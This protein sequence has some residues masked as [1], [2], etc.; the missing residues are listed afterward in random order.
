[1]TVAH[2]SRSP[3]QYCSHKHRSGTKIVGAVGV[4]SKAEKVEGSMCQGLGTGD[5][6]V[7]NGSVRVARL[8]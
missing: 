6:R 5:W 1:M 8:Q 7:E 4:Q 3:C 2:V